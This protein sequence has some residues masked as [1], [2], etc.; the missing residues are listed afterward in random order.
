M[1]HATTVIRAGAPAPAPGT[2]FR[3][4]PVFASAYHAAGDPASSPFTYA[5]FHNP[6][7]SAFEAALTELEGGQALVFPSGMA[8][9]TAILA[10]VLR[11]GDLVCIMSGSYYTTRVIASGWLS[12]MGIQVRL[13]PSGGES[14][15]SQLKGARLV[16][17][18]TPTNPGLEVCDIRA[19][20]DAAHAEGALVAVDNTTATP[21]AQQ[22]LLLR[23]D[24]VLASDSKA[25]T[26][27][28]DLI[29][30][31]VAAT[32]PAWVERVRTWRTQ[33]G[34][35]AGPFEVWLAHRGLGTLA[36]RLER[37]TANALRVAEFLQQH[38]KVRNV[39]YPGLRGDPGFAIASRQMRYTGAVLCFE[40][41]GKAPAESF[42]TACALVD[43]ATSFGGLH[44]SAERRGRWGGD[45][46]P[47]G[48]IR[49]SVGCEHID[50]LLADLQRSL[51]SS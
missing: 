10:A 33:S 22:P 36:M 32:D 41:A 5:R 14:D 13:L 20:A 23:A 46:V 2:A 47:E 15:R 49:M 18:E 34:S 42:L 30:G 12:E 26:G 7:W 19:V 11:P 6:T 28:S 3:Q 29:L 45:A 24:F 21:L 9:T 31:H 39:R 1:H 50:D 44:S 48:F 40:L 25:L 8:A 38:P 35:I 43:E 37:Q 51:H 4:G 27:H 16:W 17:L